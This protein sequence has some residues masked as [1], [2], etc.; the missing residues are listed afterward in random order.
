MG[1]DPCFCLGYPLH[2]DHCNHLSSDGIGLLEDPPGEE[3]IIYKD[4]IHLQA[5]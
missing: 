4:P 3:W 2:G 1:S 5:K